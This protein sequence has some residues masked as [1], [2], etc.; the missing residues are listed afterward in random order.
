VY[1]ILRALTSF[2]PPVIDRFNGTT[3][4]PITT[5]N[6]GCGNTFEVTSNQLGEFAAVKPGGTGTTP[7]ASGGG[8]PTPAIVAALVVLL[9]IVVAVLFTLDRRRGTAR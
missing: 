3:W 8:V 2:P 9:I 6:A 5:L 7:G 4:T 1:I